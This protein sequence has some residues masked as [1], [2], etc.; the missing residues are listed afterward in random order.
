MRAFGAPSLKTAAVFCSELMM[1]D[2]LF[3][4]VTGSRTFYIQVTYMDG[5]E[6]GR[7]VITID[8]YTEQPAEPDVYV[9]GRLHQ[10]TCKNNEKGKA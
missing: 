9:Y 8:I 4:M 5:M 7:C 3:E 2:N 10:W 1:R 6:G